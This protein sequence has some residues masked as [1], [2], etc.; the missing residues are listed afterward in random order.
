MAFLEIESLTKSFGGLLAVSDVSMRMDEGEILGLIGPN[1]SGKSTMLSLITGLLRPSA[2][3]IRFKD[4]ELP[5]GRPHKIA[6]EGIRIVFQ[7][8]RPLR[9][10]TVREN[11]RLGLLADRLWQNGHKR[12]QDATIGEIAEATGL[13]NELDL[14]PDALPFATL[15]RLELARALIAQPHLLLLDEPFAGLAP[16][17][18]LEFSELIR[19]TRASGCTILLIDHNV[20]AVTGL[21]SRIVV[22]DAGR[23]ITEGAPNSI[24]QDKKVQEIYFGK[25]LQNTNRANHSD[26]RISADHRTLLDVKIDS[27]LYGKAQALRDIRF[28]INEGEFV[29]IVGLNGAGKTSLLNCILHFVDYEGQIVYRDQPVQHENAAKIAAAGIALCPETR[30]LFSYMSI[31]ENLNIGGHALDATEL[32]HQREYVYGLFP[33]LHERRKQK[34]ITLSG[35]EQQMLAIGRAL[36]QKP[37]LLMLDEP[38]LGL[39]PL[40]M[41]GIS[42]ALWE[43]QRS[44]ALT[45]LLSEQNITFAIDHSDRLYLLE[46]GAFTWSGSPGR[47]RKEMLGKML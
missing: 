33:K 43:L 16:S 46:T 14:T 29:S 40:I 8:S 47:F 9:R 3:V 41:E 13:L 31:E 11:L 32:K 19:E 17:E 12:A 39:A 2:G 18:T 4:R 23:K 15:R 25:S 28:K 26:V 42:E 30:E 24:T 6:R 10:Q 21:V 20:K 44:G 45:I 22:M 7:H 35:G 5:Y 37:R 27:L 1:G 38:T 36:M 34:A